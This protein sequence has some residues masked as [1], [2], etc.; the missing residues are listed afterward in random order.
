M[1]STKNVADFETICLSP[2]IESVAGRIWNLPRP[3]ISTNQNHPRFGG[4]MAHCGEQEENKGQ[5]WNYDS[6]FLDF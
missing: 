3:N 5:Y 2:V 4:S 1:K 6:H